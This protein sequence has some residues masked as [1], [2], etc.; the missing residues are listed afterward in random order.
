MLGAGPSLRAGR[1]EH[2]HTVLN[3]PGN[4]AFHNTRRK[5]RALTRDGGLGGNMSSS[6]MKSSVLS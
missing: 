4:T 5:W 3:D 2:A 6:L 1:G